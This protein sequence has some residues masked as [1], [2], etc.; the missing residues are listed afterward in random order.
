LSSIQIASFAGDGVLGDGGDGGQWNLCWG[1]QL[2]H[3]FLL[4]GLKPESRVLDLC[5]GWGRASLCFALHG[6]H[7]TLVDH[8]PSIVQ[9]AD[10]FSSG[11]TDHTHWVITD[12]SEYLAH[13][14][15]PFDRIVLLDG[16]VHCL[17]RQ[18]I[19]T[20]SRACELLAPGGIIYVDGPSSQDSHFEYFRDH[21]DPVDVD[22]FED[23]CGCSGDIKLEPF[24]FFHPGE[25]PLLLLQRGLEIIYQESAV[26]EW[27]TLK[28]IAIGR[29]PL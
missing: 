14:V 28:S 18:N 6:S 22:T 11:L 16:T 10:E 4:P 25:L 21:Y 9:E 8:D 26:C 2:I 12:A 5:S 7:L 17:K 13:A 24:C 1:S 23:L 3:R 15:H 19:E 29:K 27:Q 20:I